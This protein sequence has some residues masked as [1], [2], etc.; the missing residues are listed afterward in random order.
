MPKQLIRRQDVDPA[1]TWAL[2]AIYQTRAELLEDMEALKGMIPE[3]TA[4]K[5]RLHIA[6]NI[7]A[8]FKTEEKIERLLMKVNV[9]TGLKYNEDL[10]NQE[11]QGDSLL[12][13]N[14][15]NDYINLSS[16]ISPELSALPEA[17][18]KG[19]SE[20]ELLKGYKFALEKLMALKPHILSP[21]KEEAYASLSEVRNASSTTYSI[22]TNAELKFPE[23][24]DGEGASH[25]LTAGSYR[26]FIES[27][28]RVL[29]QNAFETMHNTYGAF[30]STLASLLTTSMKSWN[31]DTLARGYRDPVEKALKVNNIPVEVFHSALTNIES[32]IP[33]LK[34][35]VDLKRRSLRLEEMHMYDLY[36]PIAAGV[37][38]KYSFD[39][40]VAVALAALQ[41]MGEEYTALFKQGVGEGW[42]D[43]Y[44]N[45]GKRSGAY[46]SGAYDTYP[47]ISLNFDG[48][49]NDVSTLVHE[50]GHS[51]HSWY[52]RKHQPYIYGDYSIFLAEVASTCSEKL[53]IHSLI[54][55]TEDRETK[56]ALLNQEAEQIRT[57]VFRQLMFAEFEMIT[58]D[59]LIRGEAL[60]A[61]DLDGIWLEL[62]RK[63]YGGAVVIDDGIKYEWGRIPH[64][65]NDFYVYQY[66][67][68]YAA[69]S[70]FAGQILETGG[71]AADRY[72]N[73]LLKAGSS[74]Y[75]V[76][77][78]KDA[79]VDMTSPQPILDTIRN[80]TDIIDELEKL[81]QA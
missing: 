57:T 50:M 64:F 75:P 10:T 58:H 28:D 73:S 52:T 48:S 5:G 46:S 8:C 21:D 31:V 81:I 80:F 68:G 32:G 71:A 55:G 42:I 79:G 24:V 2:G 34:R 23:I 7:L 72:I 67:T 77:V 35:Y 12:A 26:K 27:R 33:A 51:I 54:Q 39:E 18:L 38:R 60:T 74:K 45:L 11:T 47:Y 9:Y 19:M 61:A 22:F 15:L 14:L 30:E 36:V 56:I 43:R 78:L 29:R 13:D 69:A 66:A 17:E 37:S 6:E 70:S 63:Y 40:A 3:I 1:D 76:D 44:E 65:Y 25:L 59:K 4:Y 41:P 16:Y 20:D 62:N 49:L 53:L